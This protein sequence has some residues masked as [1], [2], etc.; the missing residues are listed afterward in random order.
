MEDAASGYS[1]HGLRDFAVA[2]SSCRSRPPLRPRLP[3]WVAGSV[4]QLC[5]LHSQAAEG[6]R[7]TSCANSSDALHRSTRAGWAFGTS[8]Q[9]CYHVGPAQS[10]ARD[11]CRNRVHYGRCFPSLIYNA[12][13]PVFRP[14]NR[15]YKCLPGDDINLVVTDVIGT[16]VLLQA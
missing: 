7:R 14:L 12:K 1:L 2:R 16:K 4:P 13:T 8:L 15:Y 10:G 6:S 9:E 3:L 11:L 5:S